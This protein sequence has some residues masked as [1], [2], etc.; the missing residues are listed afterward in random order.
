[1]KLKQLLKDPKKRRQILIAGGA[2]VV[3]IV[4]LV[5]HK[6]SSSTTTEPESTATSEPLSLPAEKASEGGGGGGSTGSG[7][8][9]EQLGSE[10][11]SA[12]G[13]NAAAQAAENAQTQSDIAGL[14]SALQ[15]AYTNQTPGAGED[16]T[17]PA[18]T[19]TPLAKANMLVNQEAGNPR[20]GKEYKETTLDGKPAHEYTTKQVG[21][22][23][24]GGKF[25]VLPPKKAAPK[26]APA[27]AAVKNTQA[28][29]PREGQSFKAGTY[30]GK[31][32]HIY[33]HAVKGGVGAKHNIVIV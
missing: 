7:A 33:T 16:A 28:G 18:Q 22:V 2:I 9:D 6:K 13:A 21:G 15:S 20:K 25:I 26:T 4:L 27:P 30:K 12:L 17:A 31:K 3:L 23:G 32:A 14:A 10:I 8:S 5:L 11:T 29:N 1:M 24:P 19:K